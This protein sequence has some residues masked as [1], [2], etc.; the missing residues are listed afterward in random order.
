MINEKR[1]V[2]I[3]D[4]K[5]AKST[6]VLFGGFAAFFLLGTVLTGIF[7]PRANKVMGINGDDTDSIKTFTSFNNGDE[8]AAANS[9]TLQRFSMEDN[10]V[11]QSI[12]Y[13]QEI[14][15]MLKDNSEYYNSNFEDVTLHYEATSSDDGY[16]LVFD[17]DGDIF[18]Y[19]F[20]DNQLTLNEHYW[21]TERIYIQDKLYKSKYRISCLAVS[22]N[23]LY[24]LFSND[25]S[26]VINVYDVNNLNNGVLRS[27]TLISLDAPNKD[28]KVEYGKNCYLINKVTTKRHVYDF[29]I[30]GEYVSILTGQGLTRWNKN[31]LDYDDGSEQ[32][33][34]LNDANKFIDEAMKA[35]LIADTD[36]KAELG[37]DDETITA[38]SDFAIKQMYQIAYGD[39]EYVTKLKLAAK[40]FKNSKTWVKEYD[41]VKEIYVIESDHYDDR[42]NLDVNVGS[43]QTM[44]GGAYS[45][46]DKVVYYLD[47]KSNTLFTY[48]IDKIAALHA[49]ENK[50]LLDIATETNVKYKGVSFYDIKGN[51]RYEKV[52]NTIQVYFYSSQKI[53]IVD[54]NGEEPVEKIRFALEYDVRSFVSNKDGSR[55]AGMY[56]I[57]KRTIKNVAS[58]PLVISVVNPS[59]YQYRIFFVI[60]FVACIALF[61]VSIIVL[62]ISLKAYKRTLTMLKLK[63]IQRDLKRNKWTY[64]ALIPFIAALIMFCYIEA[65]GSISF[66]F[67]S[68]TQQK[69]SYIWNT[70][71]NYIEIFNDSKF[72]LMF[73][74]TA[75]FLV[76]DLFLGIVPPIIFAFFLSIIK[77]HKLSGVLRAL[78]FI[79]A[80]VPGIATLLIWKV[81]IFGD[82]GV[83]NQ[84]ILFFKTGTTVA[85]PGYQP[86]NFLHDESLSRW[87]L[88][89][90]GFPYVG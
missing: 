20:A 58:F 40:D 14:R 79:P 16:L 5:K 71:G 69:P 59:T 29:A 49:N 55:I 75:F 37:V 68:Y 17:S 72:W 38:A 74:N 44:G 61:A 85:K 60:L 65:V 83:L 3:N 33:N 8:F 62:L 45:T 30:D 63:V 88:L 82:T 2:T 57:E 77:N 10:E 67:F 76:F 54:I 48:S 41:P 4:K 24:A 1:A 53:S 23:E 22:D 6:C 13:E 80:V 21:L 50:T 47:L 52:T 86:I 34:Y 89:L 11:L 12:P 36:K 35:E 70:F 43:N 32:I 64:V 87:S 18:K 27:K 90:M 56:Q 19:D 28:Q 25:S 7:T 78:M 42:Y 51:I 46:K 39:T 26:F 73:G 31:F 9:E 81:G 84:L 15:G 66:S